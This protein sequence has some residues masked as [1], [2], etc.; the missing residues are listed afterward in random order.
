MSQKIKLE[1]A[2]FSSKEKAKILSSFFKTWKGQYGEW[3][4]FLWVKVPEQ[5]KIA[6]KIFKKISF[7]DLQ[8]LLDSEIHEERLTALL[9]LTYSYEFSKKQKNSKSCEEIFHFYLKNLKAVNNW[10]LVD[11]SAPKIVWNFLQDKDKKILY[12]LAESKVLWER[13]V[14]IL[15]TFVFLKKWD[16]KDLFALSE[17]LLS[18]KEDLIHKSV[19]WMLREAWKMESKPVE[20]FLKKFYKK[21]PRTTLRYAIE[22]FEELKRKKFLAW[23][24]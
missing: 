5:R 6:K 22:K 11:L 21:I 4:K 7:E 20:N 19:G 13:R 23:K 3:D 24:F 16:F 1:L 15:S 2:S 17:I 10:D 8:I 12:T 14:A 18:D 9:I